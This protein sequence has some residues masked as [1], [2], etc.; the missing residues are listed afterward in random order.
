MWPRLP[1]HVGPGLGKVILAALK[2][3]RSSLVP[4]SSANGLGDTFLTIEEKSA[5]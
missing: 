5:S 3:T 2:E 1:L 4:Q